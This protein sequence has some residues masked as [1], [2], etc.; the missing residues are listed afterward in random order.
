[1]T[2]NCI[3]GC[4]DVLEAPALFLVILNVKESDSLCNQVWFDARLLTD[5]SE[6]S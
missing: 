1:M 3:S 4:Q 2:S 6:D 5:T